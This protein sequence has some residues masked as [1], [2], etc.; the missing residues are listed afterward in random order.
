MS[1]ACR[2]AAAEEIG[3]SKSSRRG[4]KHLKHINTICPALITWLLQNNRVGH[5]HSWKV[6]RQGLFIG[7]QHANKRIGASV[8]NKGRLAVHSMHGS[9]R[10]RVQYERPF[11]VARVGGARLQRRTIN[12][13][14]RRLKN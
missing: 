6:N 14:S 2:R 12:S 1:G 5:S 3:V 4:A 13:C 10:P 7:L 8:V 11:D 9:A